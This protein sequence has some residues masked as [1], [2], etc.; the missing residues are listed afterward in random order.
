M[1]F[2]VL[3][4][5]SKIKLMYKCCVSFSIVF[6]ISELKPTFFFL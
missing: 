1:Y 3:L 2:K 5:E 4:N 6:Q